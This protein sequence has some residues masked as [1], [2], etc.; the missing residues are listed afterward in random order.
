[1]SGSSENLGSRSVEAAPAPQA[2]PNAPAEAGG[3]PLDAAPA[4]MDKVR[5][6]ASSRAAQNASGQKGDDDDQQQKQVKQKSPAALAKDR[7]LL[8]ARLLKAA[9]TPTRMKQE[10]R[11]ELEKKQEK[12]EVNIKKLRRKKDNHGLSLAVMQ[13]RAVV[14]DI[15]SLA[16][17]SLERLRDLWL[18]L[19]HG[20]S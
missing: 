3:L 5:E 16:R 19:V 18:K 1:M 10:I 14:R 20:L 12:L 6:M 4:G 15:E 9:P 2:A 11:R 17:I 7:E 13:L 8:K